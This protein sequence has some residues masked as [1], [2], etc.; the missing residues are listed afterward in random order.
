MLEEGA[1]DDGSGAVLVGDG[2]E[3][4]AERVE[5]GENHRG[6]GTQLED[7]G[8]V[9]GVLA[10]GAPVDEA[11]GVGVLPGDELSELFDKRDCKISGGGNGSGERG[12]VEK[13]GATICGDDGRGG[14]GDDAGF[15]FGAGEG[16][17]EIEQELDGSRVREERFDGWR[18]EEAIEERHEESVN[19]PGRRKNDFVRR[20]GVR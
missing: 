19:V 4:I 11:G 17:F 15:G 5:V 20:E 7:E 14:G 9:D 18:V 2:G 6:C 1:G 12:K 8:G 16:G 3:G 13:F 10:G